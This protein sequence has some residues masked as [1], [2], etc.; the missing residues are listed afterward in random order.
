MANFDPAKA[1]IAVELPDNT[2]QEIYPANLRDAFDI[3]LDAVAAEI[4]DVST[5]ADIENIINNY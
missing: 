5:T 2:A 4:R 3:A 1:A